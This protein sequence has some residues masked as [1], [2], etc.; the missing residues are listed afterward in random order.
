MLINLPIESLEERYSA[1]WNR[2]FPIAFSGLGVQFL[3]IHPNIGGDINKISRGQFLDVVRTNEFKAHQIAWLLSLFDQEKIKANDVIF[4]QDLW[5]PGLESLFYVRDGLG[6]DFKIAGLLHAGTY[7]PHDFLTQ[8]GMERWA[9][10][11]ETAWWSEVDAVFV[12]T[13]FHKQMLIHRRMFTSSD[14]LYVTGFPLFQEP[15]YVEPE[16][17]QNIVVFPHRLA[18]EKAPEEFETL[19][20][21]CGERLPNWEF[22]RTKDVCTTKQDYYELLRKSKVAVSCA[23]QET[24]GI[25]QQ[26]ALFRGCIPV[27]PDRLSYRELYEPMFRY[28]TLEQAADMMVTFALSW[29]EVVKGSDFCAV[30][31]WNSLRSASSILRMISTMRDKG[32]AV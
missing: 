8:R 30:A 22:I 29:N 16:E 7:D 24:W 9:R 6:I 23:K 5:Y 25:A 21:L 4:L 14:R 20:Q 10:G 11:I 31:Q 15:Q 28:Q 17:K 1:A 13:E 12:A 26:E 32:W 27:V 2:H 18:P 3:T 19:K